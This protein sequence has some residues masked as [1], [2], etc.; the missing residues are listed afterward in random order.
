M[1]V[2]RWATTIGVSSTYKY[3]N[4]NQVVNFN[5]ATVHIVEYNSSWQW[6][7]SATKLSQL[8]LPVYI[9]MY[10]ACVVFSFIKIM[11]G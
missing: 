6:C 5:I 1:Y 9:G 8:W 3:I 7:H 2:P 10:V 4:T 11:H